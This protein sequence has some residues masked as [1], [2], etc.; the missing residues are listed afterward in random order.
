MNES[1]EHMTLMREKKG[2]YWVFVGKPEGGRPLGRPRCRLKDN[3]KMDLQEVGW[4]GI[5]WIG[6]AQ[7]RDR[8]G[9]VVNALMNLRVP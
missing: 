3:I 1:G 7:G 6:V 9:A 8:W 2:A 4:W 5:Y